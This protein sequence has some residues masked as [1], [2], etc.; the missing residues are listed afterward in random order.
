MDGGRDLHFF[1]KSIFGGRGNDGVG[2]ERGGWNRL[3]PC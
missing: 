1:E 3:E 2:G